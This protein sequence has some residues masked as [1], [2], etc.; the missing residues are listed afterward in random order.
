MLC[1]V[2]EGRL[3]IE[4]GI[5]DEMGSGLFGGY[6]VMMLRERTGNSSRTYDLQR[7]WLRKGCLLAALRI[8]RSCIDGCFSFCGFVAKMGISSREGWDCR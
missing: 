2:A 5:P 1:Y 8:Q 3:V 7:K 4:L 6:S